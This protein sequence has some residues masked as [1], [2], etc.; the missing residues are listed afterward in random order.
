MTHSWTEAIQQDDAEEALWAVLVEGAE[1]LL[2]TKSRAA[3]EALADQINTSV[4]GLRLAGLETYG[5][6]IVVIST[7]TP[8]NHWKQC[9]ELQDELIAE[10]Q[11]QLAEA[12][13]GAPVRA[14]PVPTDGQM[15]AAWLAATD[16]LDSGLPQSVRL[17]TSALIRNLLPTPARNL[18]GE[19]SPH[20]E[21][22]KAC[23]EAAGAVVGKYRRAALRRVGERHE[24]ATLLPA[25]V[26]DVIRLLAKQGL[27]RLHTVDP[28]QLL[29][30]ERCEEDLRAA[31]LFGL[32]GASTD[33]IW[34]TAYAAALSRCAGVHITG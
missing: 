12:S 14:L 13:Q 3:A 2:C 21:L 22:L 33:E 30:D 32:T 17:Y 25:E 31:Q 20:E 4:Q 26:R 15:T 5:H 7:L 8:A 10:L 34:R 1:A 18:A 9:C 24:Q 11:H 19:P 6:A 27:V 29:A 16:Q 23:R 28:D